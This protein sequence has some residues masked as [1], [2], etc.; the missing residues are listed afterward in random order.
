MKNREIAALF[1]H[2]EGMVKKWI[3]EIFDELDARNRQNAVKIALERGIL[4]P[5][6]I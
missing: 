3:R 2:S 6:Q 5:D 1:N 4:T